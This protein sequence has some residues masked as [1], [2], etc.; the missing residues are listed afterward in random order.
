MDINLSLR[1]IRSDIYLI[2]S[3]SKVSKDTRLWTPHL[4][5]LIHKYMA[6]AKRETYQRQQYID[7]TWIQDLGIYTVTGLDSAEELSVECVGLQ[8][9]KV[10]LPRVL[11]L[12]EDKGV[13]RLAG[14]SQQKTFYP[15]NFER[16]FDLDRTSMRA[17]FNHFFR[18][19]NA[20]YFDPNPHEIRV[21][22][23]LDNPMDGTYFDNTIQNFIAHDTSYTVSGGTIVYN[24]A[25]LQPG[26]VFTGSVNANTY[27]GAGN[28]Y[29]TVQRRKMT[30]DDP[31]PATFQL[32]D[33]VSM[34]ILTKE[35][36]IEHKEVA[37]I[38][39]DNADQLTVL[40]NNNGGA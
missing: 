10:I 16:F 29:L 23:V 8:L 14:T 27:T 24:G 22:L 36:G 37:D 25:T 7:P 21:A 4:E 2:A 12:P 5:H 32:A 18:V 13:A 26:A 28:V 19:G 38:K 20:F 30:E 1:A 11:S 31:Y 35:L 15:I 3:R 39:N 34:M 40:Q 17:R 33:F 9:G 6:R